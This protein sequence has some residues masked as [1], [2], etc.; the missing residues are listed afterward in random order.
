MWVKTA[1]T[2]CCVIL[3]SGDDASRATVMS[4]DRAFAGT[5]NEL[6][7][8]R[9]EKGGGGGREGGGR[10]LNSRD[11]LKAFRYAHPTMS[12]KVTNFVQVQVSSN[13]TLTNRY[14]YHSTHTHTGTRFVKQVQ[15]SCN[16]YKF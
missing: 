1:V 2:D 7:D 8:V 3:F 9:K 10:R 4:N 11:T 5:K 6:K 13:K 12:K 15:V 16:R 14:K